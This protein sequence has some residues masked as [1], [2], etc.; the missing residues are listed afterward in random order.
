MKLLII[1]YLCTAIGFFLAEIGKAR[2]GMSRDRVLSKTSDEVDSR[3]V[4][5]LAEVDS[6]PVFILAELLLALL[7][8]LWVVLI[9]VSKI[10]NLLER[11]RSE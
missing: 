4:F 11:R 1:C 5:I 8:P 9:T 3:P 10:Q 7:W 6:W 2:S